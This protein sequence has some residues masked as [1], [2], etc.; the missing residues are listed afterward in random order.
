MVSKL[1]TFRSIWRLALLISGCGAPATSR[2]IPSAAQVDLV[3]VGGDIRTM[4]P[5]HPHAQA[6]AIAG[7]VI[8]EIGTTEAITA[9]ASATTRV[10]AVGRAAD[11]TIYDRPLVAD[12][13]LLETRIDYTIV[14]GDVVFDR[15][16][17]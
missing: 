16:A 2:V 15:L 3:V 1:M 14:E 7:G 12:R 10:I 17:K 13:T 9:K 4:D 6:L 8:V 5:A 11:L